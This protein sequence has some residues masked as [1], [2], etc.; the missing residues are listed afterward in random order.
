[1]RYSNRID[2]LVSSIIYL[3]THTYYWARSPEALARELS[4]DERELELTFDGFPGL[5]R[6]SRRLAPHGQHY[7][8]L[9]ARYAQREG[10]D[11]EDPEEMSYIKPLNADKLGMLLDFVLKMTE[12]EKAAFRGWTANIVSIVAVIISA[13]AVVWAATLKL[14]TH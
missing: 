5:F 1:M 10:A 7:Y 11:T 6:K 14:S 8:A 9:Q 2:Y 3:G 12:H 4:L 13:I